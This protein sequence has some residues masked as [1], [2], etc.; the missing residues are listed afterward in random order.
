MT[1]DELHQLIEKHKNLALKF[2]SKDEE[3]SMVCERFA[4]FL[5]DYPLHSG[6]SDSDTEENLWENF[7]EVEAEVGNYWEDAFPEGVE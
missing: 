7:K 3:K 4:G 5:E 1:E 2:D 6:L